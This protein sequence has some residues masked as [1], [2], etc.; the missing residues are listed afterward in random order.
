MCNVIW[1]KQEFIMQLPMII[2]VKGDHLTKQAF[3]K[4]LSMLILN[5]ILHHAVSLKRNTVTIVNQLL[6]FYTLPYL[7]IKCFVSRVL[8]WIALSQ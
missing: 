7:R 5:K 8:L 2:L 1:Q 3:I 6:R 4:Q